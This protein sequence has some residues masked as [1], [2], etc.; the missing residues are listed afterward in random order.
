MHLLSFRNNSLLSYCLFCLDIDYFDTGSHCVGWF[1]VYY[2][3]VDFK[4]TGLNSLTATLLAY[5]PEF[6]YYLCLL[7]WTACS[8]LLQIFW[9][10]FSFLLF[11]FFLLHQLFCCCDSYSFFSSFFFILP[12]L[13]LFLFPLILLNIIT[14]MFHCF[15]LCF[16]ISSSS[17]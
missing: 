14:I 6:C 3:V 11:L 4:L 13:L 12:P 16:P 2:V 5:H 10:W 17:Q 1:Q 8:F 9:W 7:L 15:F